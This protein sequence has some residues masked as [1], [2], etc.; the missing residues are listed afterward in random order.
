MTVRRQ[1]PVASLVV[2]D[3]VLV[4]PGGRIPADGAITS[5][6]VEVD[7]SMITGESKPVAKEPGDRVVA[8]TVATDS[9]IR[10]K[11]EEVGEGTAL[12][13]IQRLVAE[14]QRS[15]S[16]AQ[17]LA[18]RAAALLFYLAVAVA[19]V[20]ARRLAVRRESRR[21]GGADGV[22]SGDRLP[23]RPG[24]R[25]P[26]GGLHLHRARRPQRDPGQGQARS[27][28]GPTHRSGSVRQ[29]RHA[30]QGEPPGHRGPCRRRRRGQPALVGGRGG[31]GVGA[32]PRPCH[33][34]RR[35][36]VRSPP[37]PGSVP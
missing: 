19:A 28:A 12:A 3:E 8:G 4:R 21:G 10:I 20:T 7:E 27:R 18:D 33:R 11:V 26:V 31:V 29:D 25:H 16:R 5:G 35:S 22:G 15:R 17:A 34:R 36:A 13:G 9:S 6:L 37:P 24:T 2:G 23:A 1:S 32:S 14:A 30:D